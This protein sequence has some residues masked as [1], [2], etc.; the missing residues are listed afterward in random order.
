MITDGNVIT[1]KNFNESL[2]EHIVLKQKHAI[3]IARGIERKY[4]ADCKKN[5]IEKIFFFSEDE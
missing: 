2:I 4:I 5:L 3:I 1:I